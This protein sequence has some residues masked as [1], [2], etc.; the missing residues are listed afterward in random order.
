MLAQQPQPAPQRCPAPRSPTRSPRRSSLRPASRRAGSRARGWTRRSSAACRAP[1]TLI[2][3]SPGAGKS[4]LLGSW[5]AARTLRGHA[6]VAVARGARPRPAPV[7]ARRARGARARAARR[8]PSPRSPS[9]R[10][11]ASTSSCPSWSTRSSTST[12][13]SCSSSTTC[14]R[15]ATAP[16]SPTS[17]G[18]C[19]I[20]RPRCGSSPRRGSTRRCGSAACGSPASC[21]TSASATSRSPRPRPARC[22]APAGPSSSR[23]RCASCGSGPRAG[24]PGSGWRRSRCARIP[25]RAGSW[26]PSRATTSRWPTTCSPRCSPSSRPSSSTSSCARR[27]SSLVSGELATALTGRADADR[28]LARLEREHALVAAIGDDRLWHRYHP[29]LRELLRSELRFRRPARCRSCTPAPRAG[30][31]PASA[32]RR[33]CATPPTPAS[34]RWS[35][36]WPASTGCRCWSAASWAMLRPVLEGLPRERA[37]EDPEVALALAATILDAGDEPGAA[38]LYRRAGRARG[39]V[40][41][42]RA[43]PVRARARRRRRDPGADAR[44]PRARRRARTPS[45]C[46]PPTRAATCARSGCSTS[47]SRGSGP[48]RWRPRARDLEAARRAAETGGRDWL[49]LVAVASL[50]AHAVRRPAGWSGRAGWPARRS[51]SRAS[52]AGCGRGRSGS[53]RRR[54]AASRWSATGARTRSR[55]F[56]AR[57]ELL[58]HASDVP[59][60]MAMMMQR[61]RLAVAEG[62][63]EPALEALERAAELSEGWPVMPAMRGL[64]AGLEAISRAA[65]GGPAAG[66]GAAAQR[67][68]SARHVRAGRGARPPAAAAPAIP[69]APARRSRR[70]STAP[71]TPT[72]RRPSSCGCSRRSRTTPARDA[73]A[74]RRGAR[75]RA[76]RG[77]AA[78]RSG[79]RS[80]SSAPPSRRCCGASCARAPAHRSLVEDA[81]ARAGPP[82]GRRAA[83]R[84]CCSSRCPSARRRCCASSPP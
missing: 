52:A 10:P 40:P 41:E 18:S 16:R 29:L 57:D 84:R 78:R 3:A 47:G 73:R 69:P 56:A 25:T 51:R 11:R 37:R 72:A 23:P 7:L 20:R 32:P 4:A 36:G 1:L 5:V 50:A 64:A 62:R 9:T 79:A 70:G 82:R 6:R 43:R 35:R 63:P 54:S 34:G 15:S 21:P 80:S 27:S 2:A 65:L 28:L 58:T 77:R 30:T 46:S 59:L 17:T 83:A 24:R 60:R 22:C 53:P 14:T 61:A 48:A 39:A 76:R 33:R 66:R 81:A 67:R 12:S 38:A 8:S 74:G 13:R 75:A 71:P 19:A 49:A 26:P 44:R 68:R 31:P 55:H 42:E 45:G